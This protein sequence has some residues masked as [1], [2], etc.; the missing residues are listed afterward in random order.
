MNFWGV[1]GGY[2][3]YLQTPLKYANK[4]VKGLEYLVS[5]G[6]GAG[7]STVILYWAGGVTA[8]RPQPTTAVDHHTRRRFRM[9]IHPLCALFAGSFMC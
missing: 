3:L 8:T 5:F 6:M 4:E 2:V 1:V 7:I 9:S